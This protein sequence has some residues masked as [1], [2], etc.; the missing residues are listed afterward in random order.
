ML[1][2]LVLLYLEFNG[3]D[4]VLKSV[5]AQYIVALDLVPGVPDPVS[6]LHQVYLVLL[7]LE[8]SGSQSGVLLL[9]LFG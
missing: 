7:E 8:F 2:F 6:D 3:L 4:L 5:N 1:L 9:L